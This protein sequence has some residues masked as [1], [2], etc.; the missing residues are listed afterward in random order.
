MRRGRS[1]LG[2]RRR[3]PRTS[4][5]DVQTGGH[6]RQAEARRDRDRRP[7]RR[8]SSRR[9]SP[10][11]CRS[12]HVRVRAAARPWAAETRAP[13]APPRSS[14]TV[15]AEEP[16]G[17]EDR[18]VPSAGARR[19][20]PPPRPSRAARGPA[21]PPRSRSGPPRPAA[22]PPPPR[23]PA[24]VRRRPPHRAGP[25]RRGA[26]L[27]PRPPRRPLFAARASPRSASR[28]RRPRR[29]RRDQAR[30]D[31][32]PESVT[33]GELAAKMRRKSGEVIK[34]LLELGV[35]ATVN[36][37]LDPTAAKLVADKFHFD[38]EVRSVEGDVV[39]EEEADPS[40]APRAP[41][42]RHGHG[43]R[44]PRQDVAARR[45]PQDQGR[46]EGVRRHHPAHRRLPGRTAHGKVTFLDTPGHEAFTAMRAR[47][48]QAT[49]IVILVVAADDGVMPQ[50]VEA[51]NHA[52]AAER[53][54]HRRGQQDRQAGGRSRPGQARAVQSRPR[55]G[56]VGR[57]DDL[58]AN[59]G[60]AGRP[61]STQLLEMTALQAEILE[62]KANPSRAASGRHRRGPARSGP[63]PGGHGA[64]PVRARCKE[65]DAVVVGSHSGRVRAL[66]DDRGKKVKER[67]ARPIPSRSSGSPACRR[68]ATC[69][70]PSSD[71]RKA[72][73]IA[74]LRAERDKA[75][76]QGRDP[77]HPRGP[78]QADRRRAR[79]RSCGS[80]SRPTCRARWRR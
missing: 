47:G 59:L 32:L 12:R 56:R 10:R 40:P 19:R 3:R 18:P 35:M 13:I 69:W 39:E 33:V 50:T 70:W 26:A 71:E 1:S 34:A 11:S 49:D 43:P 28:R 42:G 79:S 15:G 53:A 44:R 80:S 63:R 73:Q 75:Q 29:R 24:A 16:A 55:A 30:A 4:P 20:R 68:R 48:A 23:P 65:G 61:A 77:H 64:D 51:I 57:A 76:G 5:A 22:P 17:A 8:R 60:Q 37:V 9:Q 36:E 2:R 62:L 66:F 21:A 6:D 67:R 45:H 31:P 78:A 72:R 41:A 52:K 27:R 38:V 58:R 14:R 46:R 74:D 54:D 7:S 25:A